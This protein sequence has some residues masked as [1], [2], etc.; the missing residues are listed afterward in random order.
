[1]G[2]LIPL[3]GQAFVNRISTN[4]SYSY[5]INFVPIIYTFHY[6]N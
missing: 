3:T 6:C 5:Q 2:Y 1:M 4:N